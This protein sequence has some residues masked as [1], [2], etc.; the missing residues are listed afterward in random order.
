MALRAAP[1]RLHFTPTSSSWL[2]RIE[3]W[4]AEI[5]A[6]EFVAAPS[7]AFGPDPDINDYIRINK[8]IPGHSSGSPAPVA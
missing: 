2:N 1:Y 8:R 6:S 3:R 5:T 4:F 7:A